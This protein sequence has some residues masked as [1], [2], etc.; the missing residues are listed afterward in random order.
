MVEN[1]T[2]PIE[3]H[4]HFSAPL[5]WE[6]LAKFYPD[7]FAVVAPRLMNRTDESR[8]AVLRKIESYLQLAHQDKADFYVPRLQ[9]VVKW[10]L[11]KPPEADWHDFDSVVEPWLNGTAFSDRLPIAFWPLPAPD[12]LSL[13]DLP[14]QGEYWRIAALHFDFSRWLER[15]PVALTSDVPGQI[16]EPNRCCS[17]HRPGKCWQRTRVCRR[18]FL[19]MMTSCRLPLTRISMRSTRVRP[20]D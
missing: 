9:P 19:C 1:V 18:W 17:A 7:Y 3:R 15:S 5:D 12:S 2:L 11:G 4:L 20:V 13:F 8:L 6:T 14:T 10:P 16:N